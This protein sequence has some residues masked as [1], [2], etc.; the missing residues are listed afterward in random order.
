MLHVSGSRSH[1]VHFPHF[2]ATN[3]SNSSHWKV[4][5]SAEMTG[6]RGAELCGGNRPTTVRSSCTMPLARSEFGAD[7]CDSFQ[8]RH[9]SLHILPPSS[10]S[11]TL[12]TSPASASNNET[13]VVFKNIFWKENQRIVPATTTT[14]DFKPAVDASDRLWQW[15]RDVELSFDAKFL[16]KKEFCFYTRLETPDA[17]LHGIFRSFPVSLVSKPSKKRSNHSCPDA[18]SHKC[19]RPTASV[20]AICSGNSVA[21][22][23]R[24]RNQ[25]VSTKFLGVMVVEEENKKT[26]SE[27]GQ[28]PVV[29]LVGK[30]SSWDSFVIVADEDDRLDAS[31]N[32]CG[33][34]VDCKL[35]AFNSTATV[36]KQQNRL[37]HFNGRVRLSNPSSGW[38]SA[39]L[40]L[41]KVDHRTQLLPRP[42][43]HP[44]TATHNHPVASA[45][46]GNASG[47]ND[48]Q[49][50][51][52]HLQK[53]C[54]EYRDI[55]KSFLGIHVDKISTG[56]VECLNS[57]G[58]VEEVDESAVWTMVEVG[59][60]LF[61]WFQ[62]NTQSMQTNSFNGN[63]NTPDSHS[64]PVPV[65][66]SSNFQ[67]QAHNFPFCI[68]PPPLQGANCGNPFATLPATSIPVTP[69]PTIRSLEW[70]DASSNQHSD[71]DV[72]SQNA[73]LAMT[74]TWSAEGVW[75]L[76]D[77]FSKN[78]DAQFMEESW[79]FDVLDVSV[80]LGNVKCSK[81]SSK[82]ELAPSTLALD[83]DT[84]PNFTSD[85]AVDSELLMRAQ[86]HIQ[87]PS[88]EQCLEDGGWGKDLP[89][90]SLDLP[91][92][93]QIHHDPPRSFNKRSSTAPTTHSDSSFSHS[94]QFSVKT[95]TT[96]SPTKHSLAFGFPH[97]HGNIMY[98][99]GDH[100]QKY[101]RLT[102]PLLF[103]RT[104]DGCIYPAHHAVSYRVPLL[105]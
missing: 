88:W 77:A 40:I 83:G 78:D 25:T 21:L 6:V 82:F 34:L 28:S 20:E 12:S 45:M 69:I 44:T 23:N 72:R 46:T 36:S 7:R 58:S 92:F 11:P 95:T 41:R 102:I 30:T 53:V 64:I 32:D 59:T 104:I 74:V 96:A 86:F 103:V 81:E 31:T 73:A 97:A 14:L 4:S 38:Q 66:Q 71:A 26:K 27:R 85:P 75:N 57:H 54:F 3:P 9:P 42:P 55:P 100:S 5:M 105:C 13:L 56:P 90:I 51:V 1:S 91:V 16:T 10:C 89:P 67:L 62:P 98:E 24:L 94:T 76:V 60:Q 22:F 2:H 52:C 18:Q 43:E 15:M 65:S 68:Q 17:A 49:E 39:P 29:H 93:I 61:Q 8:H 99:H 84:F 63:S 35:E 47:V 33:H 37:L 50:T 19:P 101:A 87:L 48:R 80:W 79:A 70:S